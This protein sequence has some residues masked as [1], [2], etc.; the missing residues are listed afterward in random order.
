MAPYGFSFLNLEGLIESNKKNKTNIPPQLFS[1]GMS[2][3]SNL[4]KYAYITLHHL[5]RINQIDN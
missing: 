5:V 1:E 3:D 2:F 4:R